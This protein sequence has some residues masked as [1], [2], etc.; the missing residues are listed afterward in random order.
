[1]ISRTYSLTLCVCM[2]QCRS[3]V[4][5]RTSE[6]RPCPQPPS[7]PPGILLLMPT[8][9]SKAT[10]S[11]GPR[12]PLAK[13]RSVQQSFCRY[14]SVFNSLK[15]CVT[16]KRVVFNNLFKRFV[17]GNVFKKEEGNHLHTYVFTLNYIS[18]IFSSFC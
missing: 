4:L 11:S 1:M 3:L 6:Q 16:W 7:R 17:H 9:P 10:G 13:S 14:P 12:P 8:A 15:T 2:D 5:W 18:Y